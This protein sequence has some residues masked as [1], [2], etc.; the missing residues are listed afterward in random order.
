M[1][2]N[3]LK[4]SEKADILPDIKYRKSHQPIKKRIYNLD[5][6]YSVSGQMFFDS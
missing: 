4:P 5:N 6:M 3:L 2:K 1:A